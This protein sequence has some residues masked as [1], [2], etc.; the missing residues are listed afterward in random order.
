LIWPNTVL[1]KLRISKI[2]YGPNAVSAKHCFGQN[3]DLAIYSIG[4]TLNMCWPITDLAKCSIG[5]TLNWPNIML[6]KY[7]FLSK[8]CIG[9]ALQ[10]AR[11]VLFKYYFVQILFCPNIIL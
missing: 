9:Q 8:F 6:A 4:Q 1:A 5:Q 2:L 10:Q 3:F 7:R 11:A